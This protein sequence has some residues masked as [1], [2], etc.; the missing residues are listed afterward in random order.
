MPVRPLSEV[1]VGD[2]IGPVTVPVARE[3]LVAYANASLDQNPIPHCRVRVLCPDGA[4]RE[5]ESD[6]AGDI[7]IPRAST[8]DV[9]TL[10]EVQKCSLDVLQRHSIVRAS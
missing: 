9:Y 1:A 10:L 3:T 6:E 5:F 7:F 2:V 8:K 4:T